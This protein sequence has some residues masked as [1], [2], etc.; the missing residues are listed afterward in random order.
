MRSGPSHR[1]HP[2]PAFTTSLLKGMIANYEGWERE[3]FDKAAGLFAQSGHDDGMEY[4]ISSRQTKD[5]LRGDWG[6]RPR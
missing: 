1:V 3:H 5:E 4:N 2:D 6:F